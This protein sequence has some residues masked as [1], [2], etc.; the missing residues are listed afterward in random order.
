MGLSPG[1]RQAIIWTNTGILLIEL[2]RNKIQWNLNRNSYIY[3]NE[4]A[5][6]NAVC[7]M[8]AIL[9]WPQC[10]NNSIFVVSTVPADGQAA[11]SQDITDTM[12]N[13]LPVPCFFGNLRNPSSVE[14]GIFWK[15]LVKTMAADALA[16]CIARASTGMALSN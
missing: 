16:P 11:I 10:V 14:T 15:N 4:N 5:F 12:M 1:W 6:Q 8:A 9:S 2:L 13:Q 3:I 7:E